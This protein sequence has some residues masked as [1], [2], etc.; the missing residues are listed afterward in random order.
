MSNSEDNLWSSFLR[1]SSKRSL[2]QEATCVIVGNS[3]SGKRQ[4]VKALCSVNSADA[5]QN[6]KR[7]EMLSFNYFD[8]DD[9]YLE[10]NARVNTWL[11]DNNVFGGAYDILK[12]SGRSDKV[13]RFCGYDTHANY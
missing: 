11:F 3:N 4:L 7:T 2:N 10:S 6:A 8:I 12:S 5:D 9:R 13:S 1:E